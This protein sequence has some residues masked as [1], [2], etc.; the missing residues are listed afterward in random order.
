MKNSLYEKSQSTC[1]FRWRVDVGTSTKP[2]TLQQL[3]SVTYYDIE[4]RAINTVSCWV[5][6][7]TVAED[8]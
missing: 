8:T 5:D 3:F 4:D 6:V 7:P 1:N 2:A